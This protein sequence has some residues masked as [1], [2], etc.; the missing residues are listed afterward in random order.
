VEIL[1]NSLFIIIAILLAVV[2][3]AM[4][5]SSLKEFDSIN[6]SFELFSS[7]NKSFTQDVSLSEIIYSEKVTKGLM[8]MIVDDE[9]NTFK[10][11]SNKEFIHEIYQK[12]HYIPLWF[13]SKGVKSEA[14]EDF[15]KTIGSDIILD[16][17]GNI[18][19]RYQYL[20]SA[21]NKENNRTIEEELKL[22]IQ[23]S[24]LYKSYLN[25]HLYGSIKWWDFKKKLRWMRNRKLA[26]DWVVHT[27]KYNVV[28]LMMHY[29]LSHIVKATTP[30]SFGYKS[31]LSELKRLKNIQKQGGWEK[32]PH[33]KQLRYGKSGTEVK[34]LIDRLRSSGDY[35]C[36]PSNGDNHY[37]PC[38]KKAIKRFQKR[39]GLHSNGNLNGSTR[40]KMN[41]SVEWK[42]KKVLLN[43]D[44]IKCLPDQPEDRY[45][46]VNIPDFRLYY[47]E[48]GVE[49]LSMRVIV[50]DKTHHTPIFSSEISFIVLNPYWI[51]PD[52]IVKQE[53]IPNILKNPNYLAERNYEVRTSYN[54]K[55]SPIDAT[56]INWAKV[57]RQGQTKRYKF[58]Q[59][60]G[61]K[62]ALGKIKFKFPNK[63]AVYLHDT[64]N[65]KLFKKGQRA[66]SHGCIRIAE[67]NA[68]LAM[69]APHEKSVNY[70]RSQR[71]LKGK[72]KT[73]LNL[74]TPV[75][76][77]IVYLTAWINSDGLL[78]YRND[79]YNYDGKQKRAIY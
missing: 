58:M 71:I 20:K 40:K 32:I 2:I 3:E 52:S 66:F 76:V 14:V 42:I 64:P 53:M 69:F 43:L 13:N 67:P 25:F 36:T 78:H 9:A 49:K 79:I 35:T 4:T 15:F 70:S 63:F 59:P 10:S 11:I 27:P 57:L 65:K 17:N 23:L 48:Q 21:F 39:H 54:T 73:Q 30:S 38:L 34:R 28:E 45:V 29:P 41:I 5:M 8:K 72:N 56:K 75:P 47:K 16:E 55:R 46:M 31:M 50:G 1:K 6:Q 60:P 77:H 51:I 44:R 12:N 24:S 33:S 61:P 37:G 19:K 68:L 7:K 74:S 26:A 62:N 18:F 22:D